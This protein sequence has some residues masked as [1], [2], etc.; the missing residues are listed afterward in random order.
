M[1]APQ[2][3]TA[4]IAGLALLALGAAGMTALRAL[5]S[6]RHGRQPRPQA[7]NFPN[8]GQVTIAASLHPRARG[9]E[10]SSAGEQSV[11]IVITDL[12]GDAGGLGLAAID[13]I[14]TRA[15]G[16]FHVDSSGDG[17]AAFTI[18]LPLTT[19]PPVPIGEVSM[20]GPAPTVL[21]VED[22]PGIR[23]FIE[24][25]LV[26]AGRQV[27]I[28]SGPRAALDAISREPAISVMLVDVVMPEMDGYEVAAE[29]RKISP[30]LRVVFMSAFAPDLARQ[31]DG[32]SFLAKP[33]SGETLT[34]AIEKALGTI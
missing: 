4:L 10:A 18:D 6:R 17:R 13:S 12:A 14:V 21:V 1:T 34:R 25:V 3:I 23:E 27:V 29:A 26:R 32:D 9:V 8:A 7:G 33:F 20:S 16:R 19:G 15:G 5:A 30:S 2:L 24:L 28:V 11:R 22:E 31:P